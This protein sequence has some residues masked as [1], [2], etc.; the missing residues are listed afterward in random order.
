MSIKPRTH[1]NTSPEKGKVFKK[2]AVT[3]QAPGDVTIRQ[4]LANAQGQPLPS[5]FDEDNPTPHFDRMEFQDLHAHAADVFG[6]REQ[7]VKSSKNLDKEINGELTKAER[8]AAI[9]AEIK[10]RE[11]AKGEPK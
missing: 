9:E 2:P 3:D 1:Y 4:L 7:S 10:T 8:D 11:A 6:R 5:Q